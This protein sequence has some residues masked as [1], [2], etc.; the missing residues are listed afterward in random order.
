MEATLSDILFLF[1]HGNFIFIREIYGILQ[2]DF[3]RLMYCVV[4]LCN[5]TGQD[6]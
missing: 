5:L 2:S 1:D 3:A 4:I 6:L